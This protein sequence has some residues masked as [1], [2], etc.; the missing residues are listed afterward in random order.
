MSIPKWGGNGKSG[1]VVRDPKA[2]VSKAYF[3]H[4][5]VSSGKDLPKTLGSEE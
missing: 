4:E 1:E 3:W 5:S 2:Y